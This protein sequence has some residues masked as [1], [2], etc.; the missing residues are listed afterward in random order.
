[1]GEQRPDCSGHLVG[2]RDPYQHWR[3]ARH[4]AIPGR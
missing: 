4:H 3:F 2:E 1:M